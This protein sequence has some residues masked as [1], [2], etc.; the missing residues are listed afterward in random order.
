MKKNKV[1]TLKP[2]NPRHCAF[3]VLQR[4][5]STDL[6]AD[7]LMD[8]ELSKGLLQGPDRSLFAEM[9]YG[10]LRRQG[11][12]DHYLSQLLQQPAERMELQVMIMLR[13]GLYQLMFLDRVPQHAAVH[14][15]VELAK[16]QL[17]RASGLVN[18][19]LRNFIRKRGIL[20]SPE[21]IAEPAVRISASYSVPLWLAEQWLLQFRT[22]DAADL[23]AASSEIPA[24]TLRT[25]T[26]LCSREEMREKLAASGIDSS[27][28]RFSPEGL[29]LSGRH[30]VA[31]LP[32]FNEGLFAVQDEASQ[33]AVHLLDPRPGDSVL[34]VCAAPGGKS[35]HIAQLM[36]G[37]GS[38]Y[39]T[40]INMRK[41]QKIIDSAKRLGLTGIQAEVGDALSPDYMRGMEFDRILLDAPC[42]G[43]GVIRRNPETRWRILPSHLPR[44][45]QRQRALIA[46]VAT[47]LKP[48]GILLYSTCST[49]LEENEEII[50]DFLSCRPEFVLED[51]TTLFPEWEAVFS[52]TGNLR[53]WPHRHGTDGF[54]AARIRKSE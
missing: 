33:L 8:Q 51:M 21:L 42:S 15:S 41:V 34:D 11:T 9:V 53:L 45:A 36:G 2:E 43:L 4:I 44:F 32:G 24:L 5:Y 50:E 39:A 18:G 10:V 27:P 12:L 49:S 40:D 52:S 19:V 30:R 16:C 22:E 26:L 37:G 29:M 28:C 1:A 38:L 3:S 54:F 23:A 20:F 6:H 13:L 7:D 47:L 46:N 25:N 14:E 35:T 48:G 17:P 31:E